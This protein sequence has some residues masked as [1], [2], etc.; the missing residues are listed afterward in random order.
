M[1]YLNLAKLNNI[2]PSTATA[3]TSPVEPVTEQSAI[4]RAPNSQTLDDYIPLLQ[5]LV[6]TQ[7]ISEIKEFLKI[8]GVDIITFLTKL[9][10]DLDETK[11]KVSD[12]E[13]RVKTLEES[14][15]VQMK[16]IET[17]LLNELSYDKKKIT[18][19]INKLVKEV[20]QELQP[21]LESLKKCD[22]EAI[23]LPFLEYIK[24]EQDEIKNVATKI[25][26]EN[27]YQTLNDSQIADLINKLLNN[28]KFQDYVKSD[29]NPEFAQQLN[30]ALTEMKKTF[31]EHCEELN[32][33]NSK[34]SDSVSE[35]VKA[36]KDFKTDCTTLKQGGAPEEPKNPIKEMATQLDDAKRNIRK[37][38]DFLD[39]VKGKYDSIFKTIFTEPEIPITPYGDITADEQKLLGY[40][41]TLEKEGKK[42]IEEIKKDFSTNKELVK[43]IQQLLNKVY[44]SNK[45]NL[46]YKENQNKFKN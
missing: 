28:D 4:I 18:P 32:K 34:F 21:K 5:S 15:D 24:S 42:W 39:G 3:T 35:L 17:I 8:K 22:C 33:T 40:Y 1:I 23:L 12:L 13:K 19:E 31:I 37:V 6:S 38:M 29:L 2:I 16:I 41:D 26:K 27:N 44:D 25:L 14:Y 10:N 46:E 30:N 7:S 45:E 11:L 36:M 43:N 20:P 9:Q